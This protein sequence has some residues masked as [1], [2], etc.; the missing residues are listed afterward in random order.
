MSTPETIQRIL[1]LS[2]SVHIYA[3]PPL[4]STKGYTASDWTLPDPRNGN[5][6]RHIFTARLRILETSPVEQPEPDSAGGTTG[7]SSGSGSGSGKVKI[8]ILLED[9]S[10]GDLFAAAPYTDTGAVEHVLDSARFFVVRVVDGGRRAMLGI[11]F[12]ERGEAFDFLVGLEEGRKV[13]GLGDKG[14]GKGKKDGG[15]APGKDY[16]LKPGERIKVDIGGKMGK[17]GK[18]KEEV[19]SP[20]SEKREDERALFSIAPP[21]GPG[22]SLA[23][24]GAG[25]GV[26]GGFG[27]APPPGGNAGGAGR[28]RRPQ[29]GIVAGGAEAWAQKGRDQEEEERKRKEAESLGFDDGEFGEFQ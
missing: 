10:S 11:G 1:F 17:V 22:S 12:E 23:G 5:K 9:P 2:P 27:I 26:D 15:G 28:R 24:G 8:D 29:S 7:T 14:E 18:G 20:E 21:P 3:I 19:M 6:T 25:G 16:S 13:L 4:T